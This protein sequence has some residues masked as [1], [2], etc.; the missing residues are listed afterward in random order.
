MIDTLYEQ[1]E[2]ICINAAL[3]HTKGHKSEAAQRLGL[4]RNTLA[5]KAKK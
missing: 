1:L 3:E 5:R 4:G 2:T